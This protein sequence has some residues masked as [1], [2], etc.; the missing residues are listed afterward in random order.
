MNYI[1]KLNDDNELVSECLT[2][3]KFYTEPVYETQEVELTTTIIDPDTGEEVSQPVMTEVEV[4]ITPAIEIF[5][6]KENFYETKWK[7]F[8]KAWIS[9]EKLTYVAPDGT[10]LLTVVNG[11]LITAE[12]DFETYNAEKAER[13]RK[14]NIVK[15]I[16]E[17]YDI[18]DELSMIWKEDTDPEKIAFLALRAEVKGRNPKL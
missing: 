18:N 11:E 12:Y 8:D 1:Y 13:A 3:L 9:A 6:Y 7:Q 17:V 5:G 16:R 14:N 2:N 10:V 15:G 4:E